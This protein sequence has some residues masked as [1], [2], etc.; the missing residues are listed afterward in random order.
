MTVLSS[1][2]FFRT[3]DLRQCEITITYFYCSLPST[4]LTECIDCTEVQNPA[5]AAETKMTDIDEGRDNSAQIDP[6]RNPV[7]NWSCNA[8]QLIL[9][10]IDAW[11][12][13]AN[14]DPPTKNRDNVLI[15]N[16]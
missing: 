3:R 9:L 12:D 15:D 4:Q 16:Q 11:L 2:K 13:P 1:L 14:N 6:K 7:Q 8:S 5:N 10:I